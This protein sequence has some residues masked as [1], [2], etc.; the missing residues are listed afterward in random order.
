VVHVFTDKLYAFDAAGTTNCSGTPK[1][2]TPLW[3]GTVGSGGGSSPAVAN[4]VVYVES[5]K[6]YAFD[7]AGSRGCSGSP[8]ICTPLW[9]GASRGFSS[10]AVANGVLYAG[11]FDHNLYA[12]GLLPANCKRQSGR[13]ICTFNYNGTDGTDGS[14]QALT[15]PA[16]VAR[17]TIDAWGAQGGES[18]HGGRGGHARGTVSVTRGETLTV[19]VGGQP[20]ALTGG[21]NGGG[22]APSGRGTSGTGGGGGASDVR[23]GGDALSNRIVVAGG[24]GG[25]GAFSQ[26]KGSGAVD[27]GTGG[28]PI[29]GTSADPACSTTPGCGAGGTQ[30][31]G[32]TGGPSSYSFICGSGA[33]TD[34]AN[35]TP[36][37]G[38]DGGNDT[39]NCGMGP[40]GG[41]YTVGASGG[42]GGL[43]GG[44]GGGTQVS[45][46]SVS[47]VT[48]FAGPGGGGSG[49]VTPAATTPT[50]EGGVNPGNGRVIIS[51]PIP[52]GP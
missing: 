36:G 16:G 41:I 33:V 30:T 7:A 24:G 40:S 34:G 6:L 14:P 11:S 44:G 12:Y 1:T 4:G 37:N 45:G 38:G 35:G 8:T 43:F 47:D 27:G 31:G 9:T 10:P 29:G 51:F 20:S 52:T 2:C 42:G 21:F 23:R 28:G 19:R 26:P 25:A 5:D 50:N 18:S 46:S 32:G 17:V 13:V 48:A 39:F 15:L 22:N 3:T 49:F